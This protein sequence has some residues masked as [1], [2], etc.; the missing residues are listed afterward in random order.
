MPLPRQFGIVDVSGTYLAYE[1]AGSGEPLLL[2][3]GFTLD[4]RMWADQIDV[5]AERFTVVAVDLRGFGRS[6]PVGS[7]SYSSVDDLKALLDHLGIGAAHLVGLSMGGG[8]VT[9]FAVT[10]PEATHSLIL[11]DSNL[12]GYAWSAEWQ[13]SFRALTPTAKTAGVAAA[14]ALWLAHPLFAPAR[15]NPEVAR[16]LDEMVTDYSGW[17]WLNRDPE[18]GLTPPTIERLGE[19]AAPTLVVVGERDL[20]DFHAVA[21]R[22]AQGIPGAQKVVLPGVGHLANLEAPTRFNEIVLAFLDGKGTPG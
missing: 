11:V 1:R 7:A 6:G 22:L 18:R 9:S 21:E 10:H 12:W 3:H 19:I 2:V 5:F 15:E 16:R 20:P 14:K 17:H 13:T 4:R 8:I